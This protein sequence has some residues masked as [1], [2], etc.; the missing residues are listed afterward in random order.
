MSDRL[1][2][3]K[4]EIR[5]RLDKLLIDSPYFSEYIYIYKMK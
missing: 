1:E 2:I 5:H 3:L 4:Q